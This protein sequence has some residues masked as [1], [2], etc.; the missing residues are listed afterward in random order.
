M[1]GAAECSLVA[2]QQVVLEPCGELQPDEILSEAT[3]RHCH[4]EQSEI[5]REVDYLNR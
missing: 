4:V 2:R 5:R 1:R 3:Y